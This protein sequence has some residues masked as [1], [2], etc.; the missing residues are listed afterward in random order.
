M[1]ARNC[2]EPE[3]DPHFEEID[4][5]TADTLDKEDPTNEESSVEYIENISDKDMPPEVEKLECNKG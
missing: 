1:C 2:Q 5:N 4:E 3:S